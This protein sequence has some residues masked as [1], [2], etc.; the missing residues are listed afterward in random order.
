[1]FEAG[2]F[3]EAPPEIWR[4]NYQLPAW[5]VVLTQ[6]SAPY[7]IVYGGRN[8]SKSW[9]VAA[10][11]LYLI[12]Q[13]K[14]PLTVM[15]MRET[16][17]AIED[18][19]LKLCADLINLIYAGQGWQVFKR[20][21]RFPGN[22]STIRFR[23][24][25]D[26][27]ESSLRSVEGVDIFWFEEGQYMSTRSFETLLPTVRGGA[28]LWITF[29][30]R[31]RQDPVWT[32]FLT[33][34][35]RSR[36][37]IIV[38]V[39]YDSNPW[40]SDR[41]RNEIEAAK[42]DEPDR[43]PHIYLG[44]PDDEGATRKVMPYVMVQA[45]V[46]AWEKWAPANQYQPTGRIHAGLD[47]ADTGADWNAL[48]GA[49]RPADLARASAGQAVATSSR[50]AWTTRRSTRSRACS[51]RPSSARTA[52]AASTTPAGSTTTPAASA[53]RR[54]R[55]SP[56]WA[57]AGAAATSAAARS[58]AVRSAAR[59]WR[60]TGRRRTKDHFHRRKDQMGWVPHLR[61]MRT[62]RLLDGHPVNPDHCLFIDRSGIKNASPV[63]EPAI[64]ARVGGEQQRED[65]DREAAEGGREGSTA[66]MDS[67]DYWDSQSAVIRLG[68]A[69]RV[70]GARA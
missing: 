9:A 49:P 43:F 66:K 30:P 65:R 20:T 11:L 16:D 8:S 60:S 25:S 52:G 28:E 62:Q 68:F 3:V 54:G 33:G 59:R 22:G 4:T 39:N 24:L 27:T 55:S 56:S 15:I 45:C 2:E 10:A 70:E 34:T 53:A 57:V 42:I 58:S 29:N 35:A 7:K 69:E 21:I 14:R 5:S 47:I 23:G 44:V 38:Q 1:M 61:G 41:D 64:A 63:H 6:R 32:T 19:G 50:W 67:P 36:Q 12:T 37:A 13:S 46:E 26:V 48:T 40:L 51:C 17:C 18:S 31:Y